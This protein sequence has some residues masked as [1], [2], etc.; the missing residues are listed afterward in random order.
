M[1]SVHLLSK[2][3]NAVI[4]LANIIHKL[5]GQNRRKCQTFARL[6]DKVQL[7]EIQTRIISKSN[8]LSAF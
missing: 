2:I 1:S 7:G 4:S 3:C 6:V 8:T 5:T